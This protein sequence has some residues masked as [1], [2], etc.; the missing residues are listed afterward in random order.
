MS[1]PCEGH[2]CDHCYL[3]E[4]VGVCCA[5]VPPRQWVQPVA[6]DLQAERFRQLVVQEAPGRFTLA[7]LVQIEAEALALGA[8]SLGAPAALL[9]APAAEPTS[10]PRQKE[11]VRV[12]VP[13]P[14]Q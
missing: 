9:A 8:A 10:T 1:H 5:T 4:V 6:A 14:L 3:C 12:T 2:D 7:E 13:R 11:A